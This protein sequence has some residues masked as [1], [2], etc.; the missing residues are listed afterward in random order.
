MLW[1]GVPCEGQ[2]RF[3]PEQSSHMAGLVEKEVYWG[4][5]KEPGKGGEV[6]ERGTEKDRKREEREGE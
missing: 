5:G 1:E 2:P 6:E 3:P 4:K